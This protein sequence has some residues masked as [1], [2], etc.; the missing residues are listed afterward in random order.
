MLKVFFFFVEFRPWCLPSSKQELLWLLLKLTPEKCLWVIFKFHFHRRIRLRDREDAFFPEKLTFNKES[1]AKV[2][3]LQARLCPRGCVELQL[4]SS[5]TTALEAGEWSAARLG[6]T[7]PPGKTRYPLYRK[8]GG[9]Q[10]RSG[11]AENL[12]PPGFDPRTVQP[13]VSR[14]TDWATR[15]THTFKYFLQTHAHIQKYKQKHEMLWC[16]GIM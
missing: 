13:V 3:P 11:W 1:K 15:P 6:R 14:Y 8:L 5:M 7:L 9:P 4:Y 2:F 12:D 16:L 10:G